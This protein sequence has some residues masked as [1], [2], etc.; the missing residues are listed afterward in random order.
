[1]QSI[2][3]ACLIVISHEGRYIRDGEIQPP[4]RDGDPGAPPQNQRSGSGLPLHHSSAG[5][6]P[7]YCH[8]IFQNLD[9]RSFVL[10]YKSLRFGVLLVSKM[11]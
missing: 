4:G 5:N 3:C 1:M 6:P 11:K 7:H 8:Y 10:I 2:E 9:V